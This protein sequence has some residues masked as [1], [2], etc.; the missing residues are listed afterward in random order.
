MCGFVGVSQANGYSE[1]DINHAIS[2]I[3]YRGPDGTIIEKNEENNFYLAFCRLAIQDTSEQA[4]QPFHS[5]QNNSILFNGEIYNFKDLKNDL[6]NQGYNFKTNSDT[7]VILAGYEKWGLNKLLSK[8]KGMYAFAIFDIKEKKFFI[9]RD[10]FGIK[11]FY[12]YDDTNFI[13]AS[14]IKSIISLTHNNDWDSMGLFYHYFLE[15][16]REGKLLIVIL[17]N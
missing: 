8:I 2:L 1:K 12:Y 7:E 16:L 10:W 11:P 13:F 6:I 17:K 4:M 14:E 9:A 15:D 5:S 3:Q